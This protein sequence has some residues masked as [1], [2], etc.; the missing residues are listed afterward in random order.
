MTSEPAK[1]GMPERGG[2]G[3]GPPAIHYYLNVHLMLHWFTEFLAD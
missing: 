1:S 2:L 3:Q